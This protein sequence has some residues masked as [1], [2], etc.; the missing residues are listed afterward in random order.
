MQ[1]LQE[2]ASA[3]GSIKFEE[4]LRDPLYTRVREALY[5]QDTDIILEEQ[6]S[7]I[8]QDTTA[9]EDNEHGAGSEAMDA[10]DARYRETLNEIEEFEEKPSDR[11]STEGLDEGRQ[12]LRDDITDE[13]TEEIRIDK[14]EASRTEVRRSHETMEH[15]TR[16]V[17]TKVGISPE[18]QRALETLEKAI[19]ILR[20]HNCSP[21]S[22]RDLLS[23]EN[24]SM[25]ESTPE[26]SHEVNNTNQAHVEPSK[27]AVQT[28]RICTDNH[29]S[30]Y[31]FFPSYAG[32]SD[33]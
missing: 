10:A 28:A 24:D 15:F 29:G 25:K 9:M 7:E 33:N 30:R 11:R 13:I 17:K 2:V 18:V 8:F 23:P 19:S 6:T 12:K 4:A 16:D 22:N 27:L 20:E 32:T 3:K 26:E 21:G 31:L 1:Q 5:K 14:M